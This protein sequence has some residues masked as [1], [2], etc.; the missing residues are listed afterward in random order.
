MVVNNPSEII[1]IIP[2]LEAGSYKLEVKTQFSAGFVVKES[3]TAM[4]DKILTVV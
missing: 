1:I 4:L 2:A 3:R